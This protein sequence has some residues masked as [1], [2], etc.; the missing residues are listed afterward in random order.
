MTYWHIQLHPNDSNFKNEINILKET[1]LIGLGAWKKGQ[2]QINLFNKDMEIGDIVLV[3]RGQLTIALV[4]VV[5]EALFEPEPNKVLDWFEHRRKI[6][7]LEIL[8]IEKYDFPQPRGTLSKSISKK[9][10]TYQYIND[11]YNKLMNYPLPASGK[12]INISGI[13]IEN[14]KMFV[15]FKLSFLNKKGEA[16]PLIVL[17]GINGSGKTTL[18]EYIDKFDTQKNFKHKDYIEIEN[19]DKDD[20]FTSEKRPKIYKFSTLNSGI[21]G[22]KELR[23]KIRYFPVTANFTKDTQELIA[24]YSNQLIKNKDYRPSEA[25]ESIKKIIND[26]FSSL[27]FNVSFSRLDEK[28][29]VFFINKEGI[30]FPI[31]GLSTGEKTLLS[32]IFN[33]YIGDYAGKV[34][35]I[36][37]PELS[38]HPNWQVKV[39]DIYEN[40][41]KNHNSQIIIATHSPQIIG[42]AKKEYLRILSISNGQVEVIDDLTSY[43]RDINWVLKNVMGV[44]SI[45]IVK[46]AER[47]KECQELLNKEKY[48]E[49]EESL[50]D[51]ENEIGEDDPELLKLRNILFFEQD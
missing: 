49:C 43:G 40:F 21:S 15:D 48:S 39:L 9:T 19:T 23:N 4:E 41:C 14:Y 33:L 44:Q 7:I 27:D 50:N 34:I 1:S 22:I 18:L 6:K 35:L 5:G 42:S 32:K 2:A 37:E 11:W 45:R 30:E 16:L 38:L 25:Y 13:Y 31:D 28:D 24:I 3:K 36:D 29:N 17:A 10:S 26:I 12:K 20:F 47:I 8:E 46:I 51:I